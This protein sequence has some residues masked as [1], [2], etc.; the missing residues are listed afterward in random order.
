[1]KQVII[2]GASGHGKVIA[3]IVEKS[4]DQVIG[5]LDDNPV[6][7]VS[8]GYPVL[9]TIKNYQQYKDG[10]FFIIAIGNNEIRKLIAKKLEDVRWY[11]AVHPS[12]Q[13][14][15]DVV[16]GDGTVIMANAVLNASAK[17]GKHSIINTSVVVEHDNVISDYVHLS[18]RVA[19][20]GTVTVGEVSHIGIG[21][22]VRNNLNITDH[23]IV[24]A[25]ACVVRDINK[26]GTYIGIPAQF[27]PK[28]N[29][30]GI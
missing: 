9:D 16:I 29:S 24:G 22:C 12:V 2:I 1:M 11:I 23:V 14:A 28:D 15:K 5:F 20:G 6:V 18:P 26:S 30:E 25:G 8:F 19:L 7:K 17:V 27:Y 3:D 10:N 21:A 13:Q 4:G